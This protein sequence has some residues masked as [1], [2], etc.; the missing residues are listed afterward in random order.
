MD[1]DVCGCQPGQIDV[2]DAQQAQR[3]GRLALHEKLEV[4]LASA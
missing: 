4:G 2:D 1:G 3:R